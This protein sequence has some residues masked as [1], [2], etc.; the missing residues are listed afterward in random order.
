MKKKIPEEGRGLPLFAKN[1]SYI[2][3]KCRFE[4]TGVDG[5]ASGNIPEKSGATHLHGEKA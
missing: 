3:R 1:E 4:L 5:K 2:W